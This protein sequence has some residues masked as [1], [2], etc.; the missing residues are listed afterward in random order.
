MIE[1][2]VWEA[3]RKTAE[4]E[5]GPRADPDMVLRA[6][7]GAQ[8]RPLPGGARGRPRPALV[9]AGGPGRA[10]RDADGG[11][12]PRDA[13]GVGGADR[14]RRG[15]EDPAHAEPGRGAGA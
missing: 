9:S 14:A 10:R 12:P 8:G 2:V 6:G 11:G 3:M 1:P 7:G 4:A 5:H 13:G 15:A